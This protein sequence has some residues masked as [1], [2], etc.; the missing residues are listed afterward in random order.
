[1]VVQAHIYLHNVAYLEPNS[2]HHCMFYR[3][4]ND[5][6]IG[7][8]G[9][10]IPPILCEKEKW[11][12][13]ETEFSETYHGLL[14]WYEHEHSKS[15]VNEEPR[16]LVDRM[17]GLGKHVWVGVDADAY[18]KE[19][20]EEPPA[21]SEERVWRRIEDHEREEFHSKTA[22]PFTFEIDSH[23]GIWFYRE[24]RRIPMR[25]SRQDVRKRGG[26]VRWRK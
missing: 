17:W 22:L 24:G 21:T 25:V 23:S 18:V 15:A 5:I 11:R 6:G 10:A 19:G 26:S 13:N 20:W 16:K 9:L 7:Y 2:A 12:R 1:M 14:D 3:L 4:E 8:T